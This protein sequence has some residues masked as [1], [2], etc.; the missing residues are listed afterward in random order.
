[1]SQKPRTCFQKLLRVLSNHRLLIYT[2]SVIL[3]GIIALVSVLFLGPGNNIEKS[4]ETIIERELQLPDHTLDFSA[5]KAH[6]K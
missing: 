1:M 4:M 3:C 5:K 6:P 2:V